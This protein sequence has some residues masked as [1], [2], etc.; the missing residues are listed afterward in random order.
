M[1]CKFGGDLVHQWSRTLYKEFGIIKIVGIPGTIDN[2][3]KGTDYTLGFDTCLNTIL[4][5]K[6]KLDIKNIS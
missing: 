2:D 6:S 5:N 4:D 1:S 3:I